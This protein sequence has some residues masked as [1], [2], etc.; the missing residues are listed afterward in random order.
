MQILIMLHICFKYT[1]VAEISVSYR[2][3]GS[4]DMMVTSDF[5]PEVEIFPYR[6]CAMK[7]MQFGGIAEISASYRKWFKWGSR[8]TMVT[9]DFRP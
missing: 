3:A 7:N 6:A 2:N 9:S 8:N 1:R 4:R 5:R